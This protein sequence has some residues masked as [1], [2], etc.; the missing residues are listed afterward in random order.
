MNKWK[1]IFRELR[2]HVVFGSRVSEGE[3]AEMKLSRQ[4]DLRS[5][6]PGVLP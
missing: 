5:R 2:G 3:K 1:V 6:P 4:L